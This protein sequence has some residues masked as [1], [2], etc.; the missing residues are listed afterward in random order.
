M[1]IT[2]AVLLTDNFPLLAVNHIVKKQRG[3]ASFHRGHVCE[4]RAIVA[5]LRRAVK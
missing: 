3:A 2:R 1:P 4:L 5:H